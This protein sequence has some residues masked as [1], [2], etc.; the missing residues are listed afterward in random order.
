MKLRSDSGRIQRAAALPRASGA[1]SVRRA[2]RDADS[3]GGLCGRDG[4]RLQR[5][6]AA[7]FRS[8]N[9]GGADREGGVRAAGRPV[10]VNSDRFIADGGQ[11][12]RRRL[13]AGPRLDPRRGSSRAKRRGSIPKSRPSTGKLPF[14][15]GTTKISVVWH[16]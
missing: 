11:S 7:D 12:V 2:N 14:S 3:T 4:G 9:R 13:V 5:A 16:S 15:S 8:A 6:A 1:G 10:L